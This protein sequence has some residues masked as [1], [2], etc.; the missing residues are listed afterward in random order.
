MTVIELQ[1]NEHSVLH[2]S[3]QGFK[4][5]Q[6]ETGNLFND[7]GDLIPCAYTYEET[8]I[9]VDPIIPE[10]EEEEISLEEAFDIIMG[11]VIPD[12]GGGIE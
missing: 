10:E 11:N 8:N 4:I 7:A 6:I 9:P 1:L 3:D 2:Y 12:S 5:R